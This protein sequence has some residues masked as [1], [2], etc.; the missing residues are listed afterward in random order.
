MFYGE[1]QYLEDY[2]H[3]Y[4][5]WPSTAVAEDQGLFLPL[6]YWFKDI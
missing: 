3:S 4:C 2:V 6:K 1:Q 5:D